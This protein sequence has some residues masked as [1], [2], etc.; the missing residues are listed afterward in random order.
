[1]DGLNSRDFLQ[2]IIYENF[3][4][5][6]AEHHHKKTQHSD[7]TDLRQGEFG[8]DPKSVSGVQ[9]QAPDPDDFQ[10]LIATSLSKDTCNNISMKIGSVS[11]QPP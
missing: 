9:I 4:Q 11:N 1:M 10:N 8:P 5:T 7:S 6:E 2:L 3:T